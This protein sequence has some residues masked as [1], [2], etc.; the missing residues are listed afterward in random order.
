M[1]S[2]KNSL[3]EVVVNLIA[4]II[5]SFLLTYFILPLFGLPQ[6][7][8]KSFCITAIYTLTSMVRMYIIRRIFATKDITYIKCMGTKLGVW[9][10]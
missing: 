9:K 1:Q 10:R 3:V 4:G 7:V 8:P 6:S 2:R 5:V